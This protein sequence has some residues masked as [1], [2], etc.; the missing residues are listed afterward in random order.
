MKFLTYSTLYYR[1]Q[2]KRTVQTQRD[3]YM[4]YMQAEISLEALFFRSNI[5]WN[6]GGGAVLWDGA[7]SHLINSAKNWKIE[8]LD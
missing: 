1:M 3:M 2:F 7:P 6:G 8:G 5:A 4:L